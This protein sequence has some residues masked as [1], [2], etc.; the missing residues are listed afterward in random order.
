V[1]IKSA[2]HERWVVQV[3]NTMNVDIYCALRFTSGHPSA[4]QVAV[5]TAAGRRKRLAA[6]SCVRI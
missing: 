4:A 1:L 5:V 3:P 2:P 6:D